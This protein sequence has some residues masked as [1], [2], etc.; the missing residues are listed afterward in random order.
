MNLRIPK[1]IAT[2]G[3]VLISISGIVN[4]ILGARI[5]ALLYDTYPGGRMGHVGIIAG[6]VA[7]AIGLVIVFVVV[8][9]YERSYRG[10]ILFGGILTIVLGNVGG[11]A[12]AIYI[13]TVG[14]VLCYIAGIWLII[15]AV[16]YSNG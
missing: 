1:K 16:R 8:P 11:I 6:I 13:G 2:A 9:I 14:V 12:G 15:A 5:G 3:G 7:I 4:A 10:L